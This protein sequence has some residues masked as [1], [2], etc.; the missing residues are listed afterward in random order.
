MRRQPKTT[1][2][3]VRPDDGELVPRKKSS[4]IRNVSSSW[5]RR[6][7]L[8]LPAIVLFAA[9]TVQGVNVFRE[10]PKPR[11]LHLERMVPV[12]AQDWT[13]R[14]LPLGPNEF[15]SKAAEKIL[16]YDEVVYREFRRGDVFHHLRCLLGR[17]QDADQVCRRSYA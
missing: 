10:V 8:W 13:G 1:I 3:R 16:N 12:S 5:M 2:E 4:Q 6:W 14:D 9:V 7:S 17:W 15:A 11:A